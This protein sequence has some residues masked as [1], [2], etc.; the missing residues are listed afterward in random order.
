MCIEITNR[1]VDGSGVG[2]WKL[3]DSIVELM[4]YRDKQES[5]TTIEV[6]GE[7]SNVSHNAMK[8]SLSSGEFG[9]VLKSVFGPASKTHFEWKETDELKG[10]PVQVFNYTVERAN[11]KFGV[12]GT[13][14]LEVIA[15]FHGQVFIDS[16]TRSVRRITLIADL[17]KEL[18]KGFYTSASSMRV[19]YDYAVINEHDY[20]LPVTAEMR[21]TK[22][23]HSMALNTIEFR[24]Y[25]RFGSN[26]RM[27]DF[28]EVEPQ[29]N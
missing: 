29:K 10:A 2:N 3:K 13:N 25:K 24:D 15:G 26:M 20:L 5:R 12:V 16:A 21:I 7:T 6:N 8:G 27:V 4:R 22:G 28:K 19:D 14:G 23:K 18:P 9:G 11:S 17:P 1:S